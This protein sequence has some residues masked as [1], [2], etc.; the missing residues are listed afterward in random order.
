[1]VSGVTASVTHLPDDHYS[2]HLSIAHSHADHDYQH[3]DIDHDHHL[4]LHLVADLVSYSLFFQAR[5][6]DAV[7]NATS[8]QL[9][10]LY[11]SPLLPPPNA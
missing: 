3:E 7:A 1:M 2:A 9:V 10:T 4:H 5:T 11:Y 8:S 6:A